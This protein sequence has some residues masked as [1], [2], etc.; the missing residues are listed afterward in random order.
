LRNRLQLTDL[1]IPNFTPQYGRLKKDDVYSINYTNYKIR[2]YDV[3][4]IEKGLENLKKDDSSKLRCFRISPYSFKLLGSEQVFKLGEKLH[5][6]K[7]HVKVLMSRF[8]T[9]QQLLKLFK[10]VD[11]DKNGM[12]ICD[13]E[14]SAYF[15]KA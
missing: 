11:N 14:T 1:E 15:L 10:T 13:R 9:W 5:N 2:Y 3:P 12:K 4:N 6:C 8:F 7:S